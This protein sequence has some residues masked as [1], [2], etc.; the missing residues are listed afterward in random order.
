LKENNGEKKKKKKKKR[1]RRFVQEL[2][3]WSQGESD[4]NISD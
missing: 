4:R 1:E 2:Q 3:S